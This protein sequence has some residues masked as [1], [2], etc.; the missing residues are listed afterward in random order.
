MNIAGKWMEMKKI[1]LNK[2]IQTQTKTK[3]KQKC[4]MFYWRSLV[5]DLQMQKTACN[6]YRN[7]KSK[8]ELLQEWWIEEQEKGE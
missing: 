8:M 3:Q 2:I 7:Q 5:P 1:I 6:N 4:S